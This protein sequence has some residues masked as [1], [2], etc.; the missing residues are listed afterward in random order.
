MS[1][2][3]SFCKSSPDWVGSVWKKY[4]CRIYKLCR[5]KCATKDEADDL[6]QEVALKFCQ[7]AKEL[8]SDIC[9][10]PWLETVLLHC[11]YSGY[12][13]RGGYHVIPLSR[14]C[15]TMATYDD[16]N[17][18]MD[19]LPED[20]LNGSAVLN[21]YALLLG[22]LNPLEKM[23]VELSVVGGFNVREISHLIGLSKSNIV[24]RRYAAFK[25]MREKMLAQQ[26]SFK[27]MTGR[28]ATLRDIIESTS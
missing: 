25:K 18:Q 9:I 26:E 17:V 5:S 22:T 6:F 3:D 11:H 4:S 27:K 16:K 13:K 28:T 10:L 1:H 12:R 15:D 24:N 8:D 7:N 19:L 23:I 2:K 14:L 20:G 21:E